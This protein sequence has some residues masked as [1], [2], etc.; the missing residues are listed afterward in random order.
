MRSAYAYGVVSA[1]LLL[2]CQPTTPAFNPEDPAVIAELESRLQS[3]MD[4][5]AK[6]D[7][8]QVVAGAGD[9]AT[10][11]TSDV[12]LNG[13]DN[14]RAQFADTYSGLASQ[15]HTLH[16]KR[17]RILSPDVALVMATGEGTYTDKAGWT[18]EPQGLGLTIVFVRQNGAWRAVH[19]HQSVAD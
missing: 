5:A 2:G 10:F 4:G 7:A 17:V 16:E 11:V 8:A 3:T 1:L 6:A 14:I 13:L 19:A 18:S 15:T 12:M 9:D